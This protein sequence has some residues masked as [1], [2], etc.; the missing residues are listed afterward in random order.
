MSTRHKND[1]TPGI[2]DDIVT[3]N[4][5][6]FGDILNNLIMRIILSIRK[7]TLILGS[8]ALDS[9]EIKIM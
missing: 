8:M 2:M 5:L 9:K 1:R 4:A 6:R 7:T 3:I